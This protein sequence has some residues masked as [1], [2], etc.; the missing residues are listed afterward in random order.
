MSFWGQ[1]A[2]IAR[3]ELKVESRA[4]LGSTFTLYLPLNY[5]PAQAPLMSRPAPTPMPRMTVSNSLADETPEPVAD[6]RDLIVTGDQV[7]LIVEDDNRFADILLSLVRDAGFKG[8]VTAEGH[9]VASLARRFA[10]DAIMLDIGLPDI[11]GLA[12]LDML[13]RTPE[14]RHIPVHLISG[15]DQ[16]G[17]GLSMGAYG[18]THKP[19]EHEQVVGALEVVKSF[20]AKA[21]RRI[22]VVGG[23]DEASHVLRGGFEQVEIVSDLPSVLGKKAADRPDAVVVEAGALAPQLLVDLLKSATDPA[24]PVIVYAPRDL[25]ADEDRRLRLAVFGGLVRLA[26][27]PEHLIDQVSLLLHERTD[28]LSETARASLSR[29]RSHDAVLTG[30]VSRLDEARRGQHALAREVGKDR[31]DQLNDVL[32]DLEVGDRRRVARAEL[33][34]ELEGVPAGVAGQ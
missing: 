26:R 17:L 33:A 20:V 28:N 15:H 29:T 13:K 19:V 3:H 8:V 6:D 14:T 18:F 5:A 27:T 30:V 12:L 21:D 16:K 2:T 4:G 24:H 9:A 32:P 23:E 1:A 10:P 22:A 34:R 31:L 25:P 7:V 11:D